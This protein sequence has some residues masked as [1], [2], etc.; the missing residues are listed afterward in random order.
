M[1][2]EERIA[3]A[4]WTNGEYLE[5]EHSSDETLCPTLAKAF[6]QGIDWYKHTLWHTLKEKPK[7]DEQILC[8]NNE[9]YILTWTDDDWA[10][11]IGIWEIEKWCYTKDLEL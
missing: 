10:S 7:E 6:T 2:T 1:I 4:A 11:K 9:G 3:K 5:F 8:K